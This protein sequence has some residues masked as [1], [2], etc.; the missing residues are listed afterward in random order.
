MV[1]AFIWP[2]IEEEEPLSI[3]AIFSSRGKDSKGEINVNKLRKENGLPNSKVLTD[4]VLAQTFILALR[5][6]VKQIK[7]TDKYSLN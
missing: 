5:A 2:Y 7:F 3:G 4:N 6:K 1:P